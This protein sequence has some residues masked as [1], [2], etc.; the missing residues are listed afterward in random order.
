MSKLILSEELQFTNE[1]AAN[2]FLFKHLNPLSEDLIYQARISPG[3]K[4]TLSYLNTLPKNLEIEVYISLSGRSFNKTIMQLGEELKENL[5]KFFTEMTGD[6]AYIYE[7]RIIANPPI[8]KEIQVENLTVGQVPS[9]QKELSIFH[10]IALI[11]PP[12][13]PEGGYREGY[14]PFNIYGNLTIE[15]AYKH[16]QNKVY[17]KKIKEDSAQEEQQYDIQREEEIANLPFDKHMEFINLPKT[18]LDLTGPFL[19]KWS[20]QA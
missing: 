7:D 13:L 18:Q 14:K 6:L 8:F 12:E 10:K 2:E 9:L 17:V 1:K 3:Y 4:Q 15:E 20:Q 11:L 5:Q 16:I 19:L